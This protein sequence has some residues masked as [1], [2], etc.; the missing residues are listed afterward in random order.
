MVLVP[1]HIGTNHWVLLN[2]VVEKKVSRI[3]ETARSEKTL[4]RVR[5]CFDTFVKRQKTDT[6]MDFQGWIFEVADYP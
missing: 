2:L 4:E 6:D 3:F 5:T 1:I